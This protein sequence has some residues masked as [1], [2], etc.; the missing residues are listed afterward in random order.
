MFAVLTYCE[1]MSQL[2]VH[3]KLI[4]IYVHGKCG[5][6]KLCNFFWLL[7][8]GNLGSTVITMCYFI[9]YFQNP[10]CFRSAVNIQVQNDFGFLSQ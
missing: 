5:P 8:P 9:L 1:S 2:S 7:F 10:D 4:N 6:C 3:E